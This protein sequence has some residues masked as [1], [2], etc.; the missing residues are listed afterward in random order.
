MPLLRKWEYDGAVCGIWKVTETMDEFRFLLTDKSITPDFDNYK[1]PSRRLEFLAVRAL[2]ASI[3]GKECKI[4][5]RPS[6]KPYM[7][8]SD[9]RIS[10]SHTKGYVAVSIHPFKEVGIDIEFFSDRVRK[11]VDRFVGTDEMKLFEEFGQKYFGEL[12]ADKLFTCLYLLSWSAKE[13]MFKMMGEDEV[14]FI[15]HL[16]IESIQMPLGG[17]LPFYGTLETRESR[18]ALA[19]SMHIEYYICDDFV[20]TYSSLDL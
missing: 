20:C 5:H 19:S 2:L 1:S 15:N 18:T 16:H 4:C 10:I 8:S 6:G 17:D 7:D 13:T 11:V 14:D 3:L 12:S 9:S